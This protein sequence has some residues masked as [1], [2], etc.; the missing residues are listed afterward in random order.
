M[1]ITLFQLQMSY[2]MISAQQALQFCELAKRF[3][4]DIMLIYFGTLQEAGELKSQLVQAFEKEG[5]KLIF[6]HVHAESEQKEVE[7]LDVNHII[8]K[9]DPQ[10]VAIEEDPLDSV[11]SD[12]TLTG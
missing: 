7:F 12:T 4:D 11:I 2:V 10:T 6:R 8:D 9:D 5:L 3:I 1:T